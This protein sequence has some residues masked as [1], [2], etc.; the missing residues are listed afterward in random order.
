MH[1]SRFAIEEAT[2]AL[3]TWNESTTVVHLLMTVWQAWNESS[4]EDVCWGPQFVARSCANVGFWI[5]SGREHVTSEFLINIFL[6]IFWRSSFLSWIYFH[7]RQTLRVTFRRCSDVG[8]C[9]WSRGRRQRMVSAGYI[10][11]YTYI[12]A[13]SSSA[14]YMFP[15]S[16][17]LCY[18]YI[19]LQ[20]LSQRRCIYIP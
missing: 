7:L 1:A 16:S 18:G 5:G 11:S 3:R 15:W 14:E 4:V 20:R 13:A 19:C 12:E 6:F 9:R 17:F 2:N 8:F 10:I